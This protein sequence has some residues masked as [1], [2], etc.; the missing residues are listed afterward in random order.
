MSAQQKTNEIKMKNLLEVVSFSF[1]HTTFILLALL[2]AM[3]GD[4]EFHSLCSI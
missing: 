2:I 4:W 1:A 3:Q